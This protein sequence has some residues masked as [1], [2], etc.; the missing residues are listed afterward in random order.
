MPV[1][2]RN[3]T[4]YGMS[5]WPALLASAVAIGIAS[6]GPVAGKVEVQRPTSV[7]ARKEI[8]EAIKTVARYSSAKRDEALDK[9]RDALAQL[10]T[11]RDR[12]EEVYVRIEVR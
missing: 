3:T 1:K 2:S 5:N 11:E 4:R 10:D 8:S 9:A 12:R 6:A 7:D